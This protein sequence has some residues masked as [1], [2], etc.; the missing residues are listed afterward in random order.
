MNEKGQFDPV[1][2]P[3]KTAEYEA[4]L[5]ITPKETNPKDLIGSK[6]LGTTVVPD[7]VKFYCALGNLEGLLK[8][9]ANNWTE[10]G[11]R[12]SVYLDALDRHIAKFKA[13]EWADPKTRVP[14]LSS[15]LACIGIILDANMREK[16]IDDRPPANPALIRWLDRAEENVRH[17]QE[18][19]AGCN[20]EHYTIASTQVFPEGRLYGADT[21]IDRRLL[22]EVPRQPE[23]EE[24]KGCPEQS[25]PGSGE[26]GQGP[27]GG[28]KGS[29]SQGTALEGRFK[30]QVQPQN[31]LPQD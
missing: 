29:G 11:V 18:M 24:T 4:A 14:H 6:K 25:P 5:G 31:R 13:G 2:T 15:A 16:I 10:A 28:W 23:G 27:Q 3:E 8:Y 7:V 21:G 30:R 12:C 1:W 20:P 19:F 17:L 22:Q 26:G 9:G